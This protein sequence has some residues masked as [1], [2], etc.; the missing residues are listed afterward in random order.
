M[1]CWVFVNFCVCFG[2][3]GWAN[4][5]DILSMCVIQWVQWTDWAEQLI[6]MCCVCHVV[7]SELPGWANF[8]YEICVMVRAVNWL[9][10]LLFLMCSVCHNLGAVN[11]LGWA[12][13]TDML[14]VSYC[15]FNDL[16]GLVTD[17]DVLCVSWC[18]QWTDG[19]SYR[20][21]NV[22]CAIWCLQWTD[23]PSYWYWYVLCVI[24]CM[25]W[26]DWVELLLLMSCVCRMVREVNWLSELL[27]LLYSFVC[28]F[29]TVRAVI[30]IAELLLMMC[31][32]C[33]TVCKVNWLVELLI[34]ICCV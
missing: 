29:L 20:Y 9:A 34:L 19:M 18:V 21:W 24:R 15:E 27:I 16:T 12:I 1:I 28:V 11:C 6:M 33:P 32:V 8:T 7:C 22:V 26:N 31:C 14:S 3:T 17:T 2:K 10:E 13:D 4:D 25:Q 5:I 30:W 23:G